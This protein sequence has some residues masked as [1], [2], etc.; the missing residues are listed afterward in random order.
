MLFSNIL[1]PYDGSTLASAS[2]DKAIQF[3][4]L[5]PAVKITV[6]HVAPVSPKPAH[7]PNDLYI[8]YKAA[9]EEDAFK[10]VETVKTKLEEIPNS[11]E[12]MVKLGSPAYVILQ[13]AKELECDCIIMGSRGLSGFKEYL[14]SVSHTITQQ[15]PV[16]VLLMK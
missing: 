7:T 11:T 2:L 5:D 13:Y 8:R 16:P 15:S 14:G 6:I 4:K 3:A 9:V 1:V 12:V 10:V